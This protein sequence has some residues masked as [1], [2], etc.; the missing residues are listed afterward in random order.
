MT[1]YWYIGHAFLN[2]KWTIINIL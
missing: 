2:W 1:F